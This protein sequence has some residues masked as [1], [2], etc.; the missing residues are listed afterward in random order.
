MVNSDYLPFR[1]GRV[2]LNPD[3]KPHLHT[4]TNAISV[5]GDNS[6]KAKKKI[7][8]FHNCNLAYYP[9]SSASEYHTFWLRET[10]HKI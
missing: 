7:L 3:Y 8:T 9:T 4:T 6:G 5:D 1:V 10:R 2:N